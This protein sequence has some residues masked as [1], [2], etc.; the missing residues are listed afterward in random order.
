MG[1]HTCTERQL[2]GIWETIGKRNSWIA[3]VH[4]RPFDKT[5][6]GKCHRPK[7]YMPNWYAAT[8]VEV[9]ERNGPKTDEVLW[10]LLTPYTIKSYEEALTIVNRYRQRWRIEQLFRLLKNKG[11][12]M[13]TGWAIRK[14][15][16]ML[17]NSALRVM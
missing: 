15:T 10:R 2:L 17:L 9:C 1:K 14:L 8:A 12:K 13:E 11:F 3:E 16:V 4:D 6:L 7:N 5:M